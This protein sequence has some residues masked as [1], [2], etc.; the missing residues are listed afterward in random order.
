MLHYDTDFWLNLV[1]ITGPA[2]LAL[3]RTGPWPAG[4]RP[5]GAASL[6]D[7]EA[8]PCLGPGAWRRHSRGNSSDAAA[9]HVEE[10]AGTGP[11]VQG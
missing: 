5:P 2:L 1:S 8:A 9:R 4:S 6:P 7:L 3:L 11:R 10:G